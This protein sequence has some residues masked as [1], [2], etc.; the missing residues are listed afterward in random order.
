MKY[1]LFSLCVFAGSAFAQLAWETTEQTFNSKPQDKE[2]VG[3]YKFTNTGS[4]PIKIENVRTSCGC[5]TAQLK[6]TDYAPGESG[7]IEVKFTFSGRT[8]KQ[9]KAITVDTNNSNYSSMG[10]VMFDKGQSTILQYPEGLGGNYVIPGSV[11]SVGSYAFENCTNLAGIIIP[12][13]V[14]SIGEDAF[15]ECY[16]LFAHFA[17]RRFVQEA[18]RRF[19]DH[20]LVAALDRAFAL[21]EIKEVTVLVA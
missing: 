13:S 15:G 10:G 2:V 8:G 6:K 19:F 17:A 12:A 9:E 16:G 11:S 7:E 4:T 14:T 5:T 18:R 1:L 21:A 20:F 3:K